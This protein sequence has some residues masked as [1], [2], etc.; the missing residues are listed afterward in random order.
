MVRVLT[1]AT[2]LYYYTSAETKKLI[3]GNKVIV[4]CV[5]DSMHAALA[6]YS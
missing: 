2:Y 6:V 1:T 5:I 4:Q 3:A